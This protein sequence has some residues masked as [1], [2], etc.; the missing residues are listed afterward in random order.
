[1][2][3]DSACV[4]ATS[5]RRY[6]RWD[7]EYT[8]DADEVLHV[9]GAPTEGSLA[10]DE[11][12]AA[13]RSQLLNRQEWLGELQSQAEVVVASPRRRFNRDRMEERP[14]VHSTPCRDKGSSAAQAFVRSAVPA[15]YR[16]VRATS[17]RTAA[18]GWPSAAKYL[19]RSRVEARLHVPRPRHQP[20]QYRAV[21]RT[22]GQAS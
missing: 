18:A 14:P 9:S 15:H 11:R 20:A 19:W 17:H 1:M 22:H 8:G 7:G 16:T 21:P 3:R 5:Q 4:V 2:D 6:K 12:I 10:A 13:Y